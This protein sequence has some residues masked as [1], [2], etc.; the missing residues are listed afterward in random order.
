MSFGRNLFL[1]DTPTEPIVG[2]F[3]GITMVG[4]EPAGV[5]ADIREINGAVWIARNAFFDQGL[6][7]W[8]QQNAALPS[9]AWV[10]GPGATFQIYTAPAGSP[11]PI[12]WGAPVFATQ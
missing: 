6:L 9:S 1:G 12:Q 4:Q 7:Q 2:N 11:S 8:T 5:T 3:P 10:H